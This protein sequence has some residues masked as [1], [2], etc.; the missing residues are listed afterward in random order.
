MIKEYSV[1]ENGACVAFHMELLCVCVN[2]AVYISRRALKH[3]VERRGIELLKNKTKT[4]VVNT[5]TCM[6]SY[7][8]EILIC[9]DNVYFDQIDNKY[10]YERIYSGSLSL[11]VILEPRESHFEIKSIHFL[12]RKNTTS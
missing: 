2:P 10:L 9:P 3:F 6:I 5:M 1:L 12:K 4:D 11:R 7:V 8:Q